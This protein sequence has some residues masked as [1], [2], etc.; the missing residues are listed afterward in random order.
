MSFRTFAVVQFET[1]HAAEHAINEMTGYEL[2][3][4]TINVRPDFQERNRRS[5]GGGGGGAPLRAT[6][7]RGEWGVEVDEEEFGYDERPRGGR[8]FSRGADRRQLREGGGAGWDSR[9]WTRVA[10][11]AD[12]SGRLDVDDE[13]VSGLAS[14]SGTA[15]SPITHTLPHTLHRC[16][17]GHWPSLPSEPLSSPYPPDPPAL[18]TLLP[19]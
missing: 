8:D 17:K 10:G 11:D 15:A 1:V 13:E 3:G 12:A 18:L 6:E 14:H 9:E 19:S 5:P 7:P 16:P 2:D 4:R